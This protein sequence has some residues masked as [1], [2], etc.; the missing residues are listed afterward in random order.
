M[1]AA[2]NFSGFY[3]TNQTYNFTP[4]PDYSK[5][6][7]RDDEMARFIYIERLVTIISSP[8]EMMKWLDLSIL[9]V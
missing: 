8:I 4:E 5:L 1:E 2:T 9:N 7:E 3:M 6:D